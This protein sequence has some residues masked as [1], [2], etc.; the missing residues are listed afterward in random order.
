MLPKFLRPE[1]VPYTSVELH[2]ADGTVEQL[3]ARKTDTQPTRVIC[4]WCPDFHG[5][6]PI[7]HGA[8]H[9]MCA[10]CAALFDQAIDADRANG[11]DRDDDRQGEAC[12]A[13][14]GHCG[15]CS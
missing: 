7:H 9:G 10:S 2:R 6:D 12:T 3:I 1:T 15:R 4:A 11:D 13:A 5:R 14:C 8:S